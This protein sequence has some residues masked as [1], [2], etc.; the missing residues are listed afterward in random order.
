MSALFAIQNL[1]HKLE[2]PNK[3]LHNILEV[4]YDKDCVSEDALLEWE[5]N[6]DPEEQEGKGVALKSCTQFFEW[7]KTAEE[8][9]EGQ[10]CEDFFLLYL[11][12]YCIDLCI[13]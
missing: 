11:N 4:L 1:V 9:E 12:A 5:K 6:E 8:E 13:D 7:L 3:L 10:V 2:H